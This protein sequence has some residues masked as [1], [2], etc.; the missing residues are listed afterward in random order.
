MSRKHIN[1]IEFQVKMSLL[2]RVLYNLPKYKEHY[3]TC[4]RR[5]QYIRRCVPSKD[6]SYS[7]GTHCRTNNRRLFYHYILKIKNM[8][9]QIN[10]S[11][12]TANPSSICANSVILVTNTVNLVTAH[13]FILI[14]LITIILFYN[15][16][17]QK[18]NTCYLTT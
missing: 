2:Y 6:N 15:F 8:V 13:V 7:V 3:E 9:G 12:Q 16:H 14:I 10:I 4:L 5:V 17:Q 1:A 18:N 11:V